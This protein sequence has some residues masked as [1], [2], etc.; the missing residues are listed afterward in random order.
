MPCWRKNHCC[1][2]TVSGAGWKT[3]AHR[4]CGAQRRGKEKAAQV[5][6]Q[7]TGLVCLPFCLSFCL[8]VCLPAC[9]LTWKPGI[10][11]AELSLS[12]CLLESLEACSFMSSYLLVSVVCFSAVSL[13]DDIFIRL[14][15]DFLPRKVPDWKYTEGFLQWNLFIFIFCALVSKCSQFFYF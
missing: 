2:L 14:L 11:K 9:L 4:S 8:S 3:C 13:D 10:R 12:V 15:E 6:S 5:N 7:E 1:Y